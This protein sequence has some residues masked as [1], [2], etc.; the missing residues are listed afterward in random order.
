MNNNIEQIIGKI[1]TR[2]V[3]VII[4]VIALVLIYFYLW[5]KV[6]INNLKNQHKENI[7]QELQHREENTLI[8]NE[9]L[10]NTYGIVSE[11]F[12]IDVKS[13]VVSNDTD[14]DIKTGFM[15]K[16]FRV[17]VDTDN[18]RIY[19][20]N[21]YE[22]LS[23]DN[24]FQHLYSVWVKKQVGIEDEDVEL[25]FSEAMKGA[26]LIG[27]KLYIDF[28]AITSINN[29]EEQICKN[30][31]NLYVTNVRISNFYSSNVNEVLERVK[32][33]E[34]L[35]KPYVF[36]EGDNKLWFGVNLKDSLKDIK[37]PY[38]F[39]ILFDYNTNEKKYYI[40]YENRPLD[41]NKTDF[42]DFE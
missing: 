31:H 36:K 38:K 8:F 23:R 22:V 16:S 3:I 28:S 9:Y 40:Y 7:E 17:I 27:D 4:F 1:I 18:K 13:D 15:D 25:T 30:T 14:F 5:F 34:Q 10:K 32:L 2:I 20:D 11:S 12:E 6:G 37:D 39:S 42:I 24:K 41:S 26:R 29:I 33:Y 21:F 35:I 19:K